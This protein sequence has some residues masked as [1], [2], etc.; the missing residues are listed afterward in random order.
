MKLKYRKQPE[1]LPSQNHIFSI[2]IA[3]SGALRGC[4]FGLRHLTWDVS[5]DL[6][7]KPFIQGSRSKTSHLVERYFSTLAYMTIFSVNVIFVVYLSFFFYFNFEF[8]INICTAAI[9]TTN[10]TFLYNNNKNA[11]RPN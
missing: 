1:Y 7:L 5:P 10:Y 8:S 9:Y 4:L 3:I 11:P 2:N 6:T